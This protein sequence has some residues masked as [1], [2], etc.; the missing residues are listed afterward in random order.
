[1]DVARPIESRIA[2]RATA[3]G[4]SGTSFTVTAR[5]SITLAAPL[6]RDWRT[7]GSDPWNPFA[8]NGDG[9]T[10]TDSGRRAGYRIHHPP[11]VTGEGRTS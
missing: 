10:D 3:F 4:T 11:S 7:S 8:S 1:M 2:G 5:E 6:A 9:D